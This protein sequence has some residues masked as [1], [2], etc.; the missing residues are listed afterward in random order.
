MLRLSL[1]FRNCSVTHKLSATGG[2]IQMRP[3]F[4]NVF[5]HSLAVDHRRIYANEIAFKFQKMYHVTHFLLPEDTVRLTLKKK[6][7]YHSLAVH[8]V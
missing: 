1:V 2:F 7:S 6:I 3:P 8:Y 5:C 4:R